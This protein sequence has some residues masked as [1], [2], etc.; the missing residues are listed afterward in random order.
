[1]YFRGTV[2]AAVP[3]LFQT[4]RPPRLSLARKNNVP[5]TFVSSVGV[6]LSRPELM[7]LTS[8]AD[9]RQR[10]SSGSTRRRQDDG[11]GGFFLRP[12]DWKTD[13]GHTV[14]PRIAMSRPA[15]Q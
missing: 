8:A 6:E 13:L 7:S 12:S 4:S 9:N 5:F 15:I 1:M 14:A 2:P 10:P 3:S 11:R